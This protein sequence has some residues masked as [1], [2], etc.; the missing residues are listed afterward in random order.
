MFIRFEKDT[1]HIEGSE[2]SE[3]NE[4]DNTHEGWDDAGYILEDN[5]L[6]VDIDNLPQD[7]VKILLSK[8]NITTQTVWSNEDEKEGHHGVH[9]YFK[10]PDGFKG[11]TKVCALGFPVEYKTKQV[12]KYVTIKRHGNLRRIENEGIRE[13]LPD[14][15]KPHPKKA[16]NDLLGY[17]DGDGRNNAIF[18]HKV[19]ILTYPQWRSMLS[20]INEYVFDEPLPEEEMKDILRE[21]DIKPTKDNQYQ[22]TTVIMRELGIVKYSGVIYFKHGSFYSDNQDIL[23]RLIWN[24]CEGMNSNYVNEILKQIHGRAKLIPDETIFPIK[25]NN[26]II[27]AGEFIPMVY[28]DF[29]PYNIEIDYKPDAKPVKAVDDYLDHLTNSDPDYR[30]FIGEIL[31]HTLIKDPVVKNTMGYIFFFIGKGG[32]GKGTLL[33]IIE[34]IL[35]AKNVSHLKIQQ[36]VKEQYIS[37]INHKLANLGDDVKDKAIDQDE[38]E[39]LKNISTCDGVAIRKLYEESKSATPTATLIFTTNHL[40]KSFEKGDSTRRRLMWCP[41]YTKVTKKDPKF[42]PSIT[43]TEALEYWVKI[44]VEGYLRLYRNGE[45]THNEPVFVETTKYHEENNLSQLFV[46]DLTLEDVVDQKPYNL[47]QM[48]ERWCEEE[49]INPTTKNVLY[50]TIEDTFNVVKAN[51]R[52]DG[53]TSRVYI[54]ESETIQRG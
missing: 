29:T 19:Q 13:E 15:L 20:F 17:S 40:I 4:I 47:Y 32:N 18:K 36:M 23:E 11:G 39:I 9:L 53:R 5:D 6:V 8:F 43:T 44:M 42:L 3:I 54:P 27:K 49:G 10:K 51:K 48:Y 38:I 25:F 41:M 21:Q 45:M 2:G 35:G 34:K 50:Q 28:T 16:Y 22:M 52:I 26:G 7:V 24:R 31:G 30:L 14:C 1:K 12:T 33:K 37:S 46:D